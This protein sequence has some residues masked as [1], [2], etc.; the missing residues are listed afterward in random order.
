VHFAVVILVMQ[1][2][3]LFPWLALNQD[4]PNLSL[5]SSVG[6]LFCFVFAVLG[7]ELRAFTTTPPA[8]FL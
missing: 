3:K 5:L 6:S 8:L 4:S 2:L 7:L 1:F